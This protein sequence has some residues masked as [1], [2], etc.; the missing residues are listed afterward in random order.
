MIIYNI[1]FSENTEKPHEAGLLNLDIA[2]AKSKLAWSPKLSF[3]EAIVYSINGYLDE[4]NGNNDVYGCRV[5]Q[6]ESYCKK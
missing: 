5:K 2:K 4:L 6:I 3:S 1:A